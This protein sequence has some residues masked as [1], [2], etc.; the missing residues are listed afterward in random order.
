[1]VP[2]SSLNA[3]KKKNLPCQ[4]SN[5][6]SHILV[7]VSSAVDFREW[8]ELQIMLFCVVYCANSVQVN[9]IEA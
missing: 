9:G 6:N 4:K 7:N 2:R 5:C 8:K 1:V 3:V